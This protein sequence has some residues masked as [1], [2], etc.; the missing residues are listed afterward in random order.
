MTVRVGASRYALPMADVAEVGRTPALT[1]VPGAP[2]WLAGAANWR[3]RVLAV[4]D[5]AALLNTGM[6]NGGRPPRLA[7]LARDG[8]SAALLVDDLEGTAELADEVAALPATLAGPAARL[9]AGT[10]AD[11][12]GPLGLLDTAA[13]LALHEEL[14]GSGQ[15]HG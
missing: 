10:V 4:L 12:T 7:V 1:R 3:G 6:V 5:A 11:A 13:V 8:V 2:P 9:L 14:G 15:A